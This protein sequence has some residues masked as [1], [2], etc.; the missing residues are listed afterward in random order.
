MI[1]TCNKMID[2]PAVA[3]VQCEKDADIQ[4]ALN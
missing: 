2:D 3:M 4:E 1:D